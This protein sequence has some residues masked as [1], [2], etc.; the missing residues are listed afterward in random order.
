MSNKGKRVFVAL[1]GGV[2]SSTA[3]AILLRKGYNCAGLFM[4]THDGAQEAR[5]SAEQ[6]AKQ[7]GME[8]YVLDVR[9][10]F[11]R[12]IEYFCDQYRAGRTPNPCVVCNKTIKFGKL[13]E[14]AKSN[15][16]ELLATGHYARVLPTK[17]GK[18][19]FRAIDEVKDQSYALAMIDR[20]M[21]D[22]IILPM[23]QFTKTQTRQ[24]ARELGLVTAS[25][26][27]S[28]EICFIP[29]NDYISF[30]ESRCPEL[31]SKGPST[32][33]RAGRVV[34][35][36]GRLLGEHNG[37]HRFTIGQRR[38]VRIAMGQPWY[39]VKVDA[40]TNTVTLGPRS[41]VMHK[42]LLAGDVNWL[43]D[44]P[45]SAFR[46]VVKIRYNARPVDATVLPK[47]GK[48]SVELDEPAAAITP[49][50][51]AVFYILQ[52]ANMQ[53]VGG[54]WIEEVLD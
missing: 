44:A 16:A 7:L 26:E 54:G 25:S 50:Q 23:G 46:A 49:G 43:V 5:S 41:E 20:R 14:F 52:G 34:D 24:M 47:D 18:G 30:L 53:V 3:A 40:Q 51:L 8:L 39:V 38:G 22:H 29:D 37:I 36:K 9:S 28:Q 19:L 42:R 32:P 15:S 2:D 12:I 17:D 6:A 45:G 31:I 1:S 11:E 4:I 10:D 35:G 13:W 21:L 27:E 33:L 48:A